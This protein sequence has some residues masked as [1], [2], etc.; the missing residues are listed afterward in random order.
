MSD[1]IEK[2]FV[3]EVSTA[4]AWE[5]FTDGDE[6]SK[7]E[8]VT[9]EIDPRPGGRVHWELPGLECE[10]RVDDVELHRLLRHTELTG[11]HADSEVTVTFEEVEGGTRITI[12]HAGFGDSEAWRGALGGASIGWDQ[13]IADLIF[14]L[15]TGVP[16]GRFT[17]APGNPGV[18]LAETPA[19]LEVLAV[20]AG[21]FADEAGLRIGD[22]LL[23]AGGA[24]V[25]T[26]R[27]L[28][29]MLR[30]QGPGAEMRV[31]YVRGQDRHAGAG[32][33]GV[34]QG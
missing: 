21:G 30:A 8:A 34:M 31:E 18:R 33:L 13:A 26:W 7:W 19:G 32:T 6:R 27:E 14:Y 16:A 28:W 3:V 5:V 11:P 2:T 9:Y 22:V 24:P 23:T 15:T 1:A 12:T 25:Y 29:V 4:R 20:E 10:G 17:I